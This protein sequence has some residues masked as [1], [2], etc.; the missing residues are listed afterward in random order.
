MLSWAAQGPNTHACDR[1]LHKFGPVQCARKN[2]FLPPL[3]APPLLVRLCFARFLFTLA[4]GRSDQPGVYSAFC[5][6]GSNPNAMFREALAL[7]VA[8]AL[9]PGCEKGSDQ[10]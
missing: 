2:N 9:S 8:M 6:A 1:L 3:I 10:F 5:S 7:F 4:R